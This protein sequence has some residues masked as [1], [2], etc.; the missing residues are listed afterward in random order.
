MSSYYLL[1]ISEMQ[2]LSFMS[3][4]VPNLNTLTSCGQGKNLSPVWNDRKQWVPNFLQIPTSRSRLNKKPL[5]LN[6]KVLSCT[7]PQ[8][9]YSIFYFL[10][11]VF[12]KVGPLNY[13][14]SRTQRIWIILQKMGF[15]HTCYL[16]K[17]LIQKATLNSVI[18]INLY[19]TNQ[20]SNVIHSLQ[21]P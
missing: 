6:F 19:F 14:S 15:Y 18:V 20:T 9:Q 8:A 21:F 7:G 2:L 12:L 1:P 16:K 3:H 10:K 5:R 13:I 4:I 11:N 17:Y